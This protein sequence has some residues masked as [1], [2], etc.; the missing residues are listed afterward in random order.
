VFDAY[1]EWTWEAL[2]REIGKLKVNLSAYDVLCG[3]A[4]AVESESAALCVRSGSGDLDRRTVTVAVTIRD[5]ESHNEGQIS[6]TPLDFSRGVLRGGRDLNTR[7]DPQPGE[8]Q[9]QS[10][11]D[12]GH[13]RLV[14]G[15]EKL[16]ERVLE[17]SDCH[18]VTREP[19]DWVEK[20]IVAML[21]EWRSG[22]D[23][24]ALR[25]AL[26]RLIAGL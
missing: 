9:E 2:C 11:Q 23:E 24:R 25:G 6:E 13:L 14:G 8:V 16:P 5:R 15:A 22:G 3:R 17:Q 1:T 20:A 7:P 4:Q 10:G 26:G 12:S 19:A 21:E 18:T